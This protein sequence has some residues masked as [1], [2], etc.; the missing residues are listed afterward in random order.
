MDLGEKQI[1]SMI[2]KSL[3]PDIAF[4]PG[5]DAAVV[6]MGEQYLVISTDMMVERTHIPP[7]MSNW[8]MGWM[9]SAVNHSDIAAMGASPLGFVLAMGLPLEMEV[10]SLMD[11]VRGSDECCRQI[12]SAFIGGDTKESDGIILAGTA[13]G[14]VR[15]GGLLTRSGARPGDLLAVTGTLGRAG[16]GYFAMK[17]GID[18]Q[19]GKRALMEPL[20]RM[21]EGNLLSASGV[22]TSCM[23][24]SDGLASSIHE[25]S[26]C[27]NVSFK[28]FR[29]KI[30]VDP[31][32]KNVMNQIGLE[33]DEAVLYFGGDYELLFTFR[34]EGEGLLKDLIPDMKVIGE[35]RERGENVLCVNGENL[36]LENRGYEHFRRRE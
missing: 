21:N 23:D 29:E 35:V 36:L 12:G 2:I 16:A 34:P 14:K 13:I 3:D 18:Y 19:E 32:V 33:I 17:Y 1:V 10:S 15:K 26:A 31:E 28:V 7:E 8:Q 25:L 9:I 22:V 30:P 24:I 5:D 20:P 11:I 6:D 27:S 4:P